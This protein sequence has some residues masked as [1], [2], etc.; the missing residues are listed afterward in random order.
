MLS[1]EQAVCA[2]G[3]AVTLRRALTIAPRRLHREQARSH[4]C[5]V[6]DHEQAGYVPGE[7]DATS[8]IA[9]IPN[10]PAFL[11]V[12]NNNQ[13]WLHQPAPT[14]PV[15]ADAYCDGKHHAACTAASTHRALPAYVVQHSL[16]PWVC[17]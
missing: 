12:Y 4:N 1:H 15:I 2:P 10:N 8:P 6:H 9:T 7:P 5:I 11:V 14:T 3:G 16:R 13:F 17:Q